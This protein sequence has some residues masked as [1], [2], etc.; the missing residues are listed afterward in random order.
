MQSWIDWLDERANCHR[1]GRK[2]PREFLGH[3]HRVL[4]RLLEHRTLCRATCNG[5]DDR[6]WRVSA[7][8]QADAKEE[9]DVFVIIDVSE[10]SALRVGDPNGWVRE[11]ETP[12]PGR[13]NPAGHGSARSFL[14]SG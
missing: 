2:P 3:P 8:R 7:E 12:H 13:R 14:Q 4:G 5:L 11:V 6:R 10:A 9:V 1:S